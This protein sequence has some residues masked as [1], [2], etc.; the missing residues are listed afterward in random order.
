[1]WRRTLTD[2]CSLTAPQVSLENGGNAPFIIF[3]DANLDLALAA[4]MAAKFRNVRCV[5]LITPNRTSLLN[6]VVKK[7]FKV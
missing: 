2:H 7:I 1:M 5:G 6:L 3:D 4:V